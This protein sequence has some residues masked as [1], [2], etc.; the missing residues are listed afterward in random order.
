M[1]NTHK[2]LLKCGK[3]QCTR[4]NLTK[5][6]NGCIICLNQGKNIPVKQKGSIMMCQKQIK[7]NA[8]EEVQE[9]V[10]AAGKCDFDIDVFYNRIIIDAKSILGVL[11]M[12]L[13]RVLTVQCHGESKEFNR[14]LQKFA[15]V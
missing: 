10:K 1:C 15:A 7:L 3:K 8:T 11:S 14:T 12:D 4:K 9:F 13:T 2:I 5:I 6:E